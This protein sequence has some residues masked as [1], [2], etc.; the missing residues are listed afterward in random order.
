MAVEVCGY[1]L[2][3]LLGVGSFGAVYSA[4]RSS[5]AAPA[6]GGDAAPSAP[7][8]PPSDMPDIVAVKVI[9]L[10]RLDAAMRRALENEV[11]LQQ[12]LRHGNI[13][14]LY[15]ASR[16]A[17]YAFVFLQQFSGG[18][19]AAHLKTHGPLSEERARRLFGQLISAVYVLWGR[20]LV[21]RD[22]KPSNV[23]LS[24]PDPGAPGCV[25]ALA[26]FGFARELGP[27]S[28]A[29]G[30]S[31]AA[32]AAMA[33]SV[34]AAM[35][36]TLCG[37]PLYSATEILRGRPYTAKADLWSLGVL[38]V[39]V[40]TGRVP[41]T[42]RTPLELLRNIDASVWAGLPADVAAAPFAEAV[43]HARRAVAAGSAARQAAGAA[44]GAPDIAD[45]LDSAER[46][47]DASA[48]RADAL[49]RPP[50]GTIS[51]S[52]EE[53]RMQLLTCGRIL[54][55]DP[56]A[57]PAAAPDVTASAADA[58]GAGL[59]AGAAIGAASLS[60]LC[61]DLITRLLRRNPAHR[62]GF[63]ELF[64]HPWV[65]GSGTFDAAG[66]FVKSQT[67]S[68][69]HDV[70]DG[71]ASMTGAMSTSSGIVSDPSRG[72]TSGRSSADAGMPTDAAAPAPHATA[73]AVAGNGAPILKPVIAPDA[74]IKALQ[75]VSGSSNDQKP[76][77]AVMAAT[78]VTAVSTAESAASSTPVP[79]AGAPTAP[80]AAT[81]TG[82]P[83]VGASAAPSAGA[84]AGS[85]A[86]GSSGAQVPAPQAPARAFR[87][88]IALAQ[89]AE[90][91]FAAAQARR[92]AATAAAQGT[93]DHDHDHDGDTTAVV[94]A[95]ATERSSSVHTAADAT[96]AAGAVA[97]TSQG[98]VSAVPDYTP[99]SGQLLES[100]GLASAFGPGPDDD[101]YSIACGMPR[102]RVQPSSAASVFAPPRPPTITSGAGA[103]AG[104]GTAISAGSSTATLSGGAQ[105]A[106][107]GAPA[108][109][110]ASAG[111]TGSAGGAGGGGE[112]WAVV[113]AAGVDDDVF[114]GFGRIRAVL[115]RA[116][117]AL[118][119]LRSA[120]PAAAGAAAVVS[121]AA[122]AAASAAAAAAS[123]R[124]LYFDGQDD[125]AAAYATQSSGSH[126][127]S[128]GIS[129]TQRPRILAAAG[130][131]ADAKGGATD[132]VDDDDLVLVSLGTPRGDATGSGHSHEHARGGFG[133]AYGHDAI[134]S[135]RRDSLLVARD[136]DA[137]A[138][139]ALPTSASALGASN[140]EPSVAITAAGT[141]KALEDALVQGRLELR[142]ALSLARR[143]ALVCA[144]AAPHLAE[145]MQRLQLRVQLLQYSSTGGA[146]GKCDSDEYCKV[147]L[148]SL[149]LCAE[150]VSEAIAAQLGLIHA[151]AGSSAKHSARCSHLSHALGF[152]LPCQ[153]VTDGA[154]DGTGRCDCA[155]DPDHHDAEALDSDPF[156]VDWSEML[157]AIPD[158]LP[159]ASAVAAEA[160]TAA[161]AA[162]QAPRSLAAL[163][164]RLRANW[165]TVAPSCQDWLE[166]AVL[167]I[168]GAI[169]NLQAASAAHAAASACTATSELASSSGAAAAGAATV[170]AASSSASASASC[171]V[172]DGNASPAA[173]EQ[174]LTQL[175]VQLALARGLRD[176][177]LADGESPAALD[178]ESPAA[179]VT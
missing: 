144:C 122:M 87:F 89:A 160:H 74:M 21:H 71:T 27:P 136:H 103:G 78:S 60:P 128:S 116:R 150:L 57:A 67:A 82:A 79:G 142:Q 158:S 6:A 38:L 132:N 101:R 65:A 24:T 43:E 171:G 137:P 76:P 100:V 95:G 123:A 110:G 134:D 166:Q 61:R 4:R 133:A 32:A 68:G 135:S 1:L 139:G 5:T 98:E 126:T 26:D 148:L 12:S 90:A 25:A 149:D 154:S 174:L 113:E 146:A 127:G 49:P 75:R 104:A 69:A 109:V 33:A 141:A 178:S 162:A 107:Y 3:D 102:F 129:A 52:S 70:R 170:L 157:L 16:S 120:L 179:T 164:S 44:G 140:E 11:R 20:G 138:A 84:S 19:L 35:A 124:G 31:A 81:A 34:S 155:G 73:A 99:Q 93:V 159:F 97:T 145:A 112:D 46:R 55:P 92:A 80:A 88:G 118:G 85:S 153:A 54:P 96:T 176:A 121:G 143:A 165:Q 42:G 22:W 15:F 105:Y 172:G 45:A 130:A 37:S 13:V 10:A 147:P 7:N 168:S 163:R 167:A 83:P 50:R 51:I 131:A 117:G 53:W 152:K 108:G 156:D 40:L 161:G 94:S 86:S 36:E 29:P 59:G 30:A 28:G 58:S 18:D 8:A 173:A 2:D 39:E 48:I 115:G 114:D 175:A 47:W 151:A 66:V 177:V 41:F 23:L 125:L 106:G 111:S 72:R 63:R 62:I 14:R 119:A 9:P 17:K 56:A 77:N 91:A 64:A 169:V